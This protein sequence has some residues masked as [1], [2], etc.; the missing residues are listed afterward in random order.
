MYVNRIRINPPPCWNTNRLATTESTVLDSCDHARV[1][2][3][4]TGEGV[5]AT[6]AVTLLACINPKVVPLS[7]TGM[8]VVSLAMARLETVRESNYPF[9]VI[10]VW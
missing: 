7:T 1:S 10:W 5:A 4:R 6:Q 3:H 8:A 9:E 2:Q